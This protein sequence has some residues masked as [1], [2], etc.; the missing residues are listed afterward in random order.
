VI[1][2]LMII[3]VVGLFIK[4]FIT[5]NTIRDAINKAGIEQEIKDLQIE[6]ISPD[7]ALVFYNLKKLKG[8]QVGLVSR[9]VFGW[10][11]KSNFGD[12][13]TE[14]GE[15]LTYEFI[16]LP[17]HEFSVLYGSI[18]DLNVKKVTVGYSGT[19]EKI[20]DLIKFN[21]NQRLWFAT[22]GLDERKIIVRAKNDKNEVIL[23][24]EF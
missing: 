15:K 2:F 16:S 6:K 5:P 7:D 13:R 19:A 4:I 1:V 10:E 23:R 12:V 3:L 24:Q 11:W 18:N 17:Q 22:L 21:E 8:I 9:N 20:T 14:F